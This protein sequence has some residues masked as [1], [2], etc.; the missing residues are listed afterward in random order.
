MTYQFSTQK[1]WNAKFANR[2]DKFTLFIPSNE[3]WSYIKRESPSTYKKIMMGEFPNHVS[4]VF[5][6][7]I[8][9]LIFKRGY[10]F[11]IIYHSLSV[12][13][14]LSLIHNQKYC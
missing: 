14:S 9:E 5:F 12:R 4:K 2:D 11:G 13:Q 3:A 6:P 1:K 8:F 7:M 10:V